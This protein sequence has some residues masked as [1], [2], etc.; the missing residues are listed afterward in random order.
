MVLFISIYIFVSKDKVVASENPLINESSL[1][2]Y[3]IESYFQGKQLYLW[4]TIQNDIIVIKF[5]GSGA[6][7]VTHP[8]L[9]NNDVNLRT[10]H[11][12]DSPFT[13]QRGLIN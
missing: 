5:S 9:E 7:S 8:N 1:K 6:I 10:I 2:S 3:N 13:I 12:S 4:I 11:V